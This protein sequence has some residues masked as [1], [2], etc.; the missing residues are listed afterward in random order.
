VESASSNPYQIVNETELADH[1][2]RKNE[3]IEV[4]LAHR[5]IQAIEGDAQRTPAFDDAVHVPRA[6]RIEIHRRAHVAGLVEMRVNLQAE[7]SCHFQ[8]IHDMEIVS[9]CFGKI[10][11]RVRGRVWRDQ[12]VT[13]NTAR[14]ASSLFASRTSRSQ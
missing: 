2:F 8:R 11:P 12:T 14:K 7:G 13:P 10:F 9:P 3:R 1:P 6:V 5:P 4:G